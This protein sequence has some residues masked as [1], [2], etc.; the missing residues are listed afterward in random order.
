MRVLSIPF[1]AVLL[2]SL[3]P[4]AEWPQWR[5]PD[6]QGHSSETGLPVTWG[7]TENIAWKTDLPGRGWSS[8]V[9]DGAQIWIT[10]AIETEA[11]PEDIA[12]RLQANT[13]DQPL[14]LL[15]KVD[16]RALCVDRATGKLLQN[17]LLLTVREPQWVHKQNS[18]ASPSP[19]LDHGKLY[20]NFGSFGSACL[21]TRR[22]KLLWTN[23]D[24]QLAVMHENGPGGSPVLWQNK[25]IFHLD[26]SDR[27]FAAALDG[28][29][30]KLL[31]KSDRSGEM[32]D[33][34]QQK[35][36][37]STPLLL[38][39]HGRMQL[40]SPAANW[41]YLLNPATGA[42]VAKVPYGH[43]GFSLS[44]RPVFG[45]GMLFLSTGAGKKE[46]MGIKLD[47]AEPEVVW[48]YKKGVP[49]VPSPLLVG[50]ELYFVDDGG[51]LSC[52]D[53]RTGEEHYRE[54]LGGNFSAS[55]TFADG[56]IYLSGREGT[57]YVIAPG[58]KFSL[59]AKNTL[60]GQVFASL[61]IA[62]H[63]LFL[64]TDQGLYRLQS[65]RES[66]TTARR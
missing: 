42:E 14:T 9:I 31:W 63:A 64:R 25:L 62:D 23:T 54:R 3:A 60:P 37:Y 39:L 11:K 46:M 59:L 15:E 43:L 61:A 65:R 17:I 20:A 21:D 58:P 34:P 4:A 40:A 57:T 2:S 13:G 12:R 38:D 33:S 26:G 27:Q 53:A 47:A 48:R 22:G 8:P 24:P 16:L 28:S 50:D 1:F 55:P 35:K 49:L 5:G 19:I 36:S 45:H 51:F 29:T 18:Y 6:G 52:L 30:G 10:T 7:E 32:N 66:E 41:L 44:A 56:R